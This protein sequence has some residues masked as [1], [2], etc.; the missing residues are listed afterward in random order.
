MGNQLTHFKA[1]PGI[2]Y[3]LAAGFFTY[4]PHIWAKKSPLKAGFRFVGRAGI[5]NQ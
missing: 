3:G 1:K 5:T 4:Q 2:S